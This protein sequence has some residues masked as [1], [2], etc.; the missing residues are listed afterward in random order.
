M[1]CVG[2]CWGSTTAYATRAADLLNV[3]ENG[4]FDWL[5]DDDVFVAVTPQEHMGEK[6]RHIVGV[7]VL[8]WSHTEGSIGGGRSAQK[9]RRKKAR[10]L[11]RA[12]AVAPE[13]RDQGIGTTLLRSA[14]RLVRSRG[15]EGLWFDAFNICELLEGSNVFGCWL[16]YLVSEPVLVNFYNGSIK[17]R[18]KWACQKL[19]TVMEG[20][21]PLRK[22]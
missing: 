8:S 9:F 6:E 10:G 19:A 7:L 17:I 1:A 16:I 3:Q 2:L 14:A 13:Y 12:W 20:Y 5:G 11:I 22:R 21:G 18:D 15:G 4:I